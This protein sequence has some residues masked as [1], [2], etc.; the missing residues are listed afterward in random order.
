MLCP[1]HCRNPISTGAVLTASGTKIL[2]HTCGAPNAKKG[3]PSATS[4]LAYL[5]EQKTS[6]QSPPQVTSPYPMSSSSNFSLTSSSSTDPT[7]PGVTQIA[8]SR[9]RPSPPPSVSTTS[10]QYSNSGVR[11]HTEQKFRADGSVPPSTTNTQRTS[12]PVFLASQSRTS[13]PA[14]LLSTHQSSSPVPISTQRSSPSPHTPSTPPT[15]SR[16]MPFPTSPRQ[17]SSPAVDLNKVAGSG[18]S[19]SLNRAGVGS[20]PVSSPSHQRSMSLDR[21]KNAADQ[22]DG[23]VK[24]PPPSTKNDRGEKVKL[25]STCV[26]VCACARACVCFHTYLRICVYM[27]VCVWYVRMCVCAFWYG[28]LERHSCHIVIPCSCAYG[29]RQ[30]FGHV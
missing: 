19:R 10:S 28:C 8:H 24:T 5:S 7:S 1:V 26:C 3:P 22:M 23:F 20:S 15:T 2:C 30:K 27:Y 12:S 18:S 14:L 25:G 13:S 17:V 4:P 16:S 6:T 9:Y 11:K 21:G 29:R